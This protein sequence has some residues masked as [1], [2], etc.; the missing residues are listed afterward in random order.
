MIK[1]SKYVEKL[2]AYNITS[3][4][5]WADEA[6]K[7][8]LKLD[9]NE[10]P[11]DFPF[12]KDELQKISKERGILSWYPDYMT[13]KLSSKIS[14]YLSIPETNLSIFPGSD[15]ALETF[16]RAYLS[17]DDEV[18]VIA[19]TYENAFV[20]F[21]QT[22]AHIKFLDIPKPFQVDLSVISEEILLIKPK[23]VYLV[24][25]N[26]PCGY[27]V[28]TEEIEDLVK[29]HPHT[30]FIIDEAYI[31]FSD[32]SSSKDLVR[33]NENIA[34]FR[35][36]S[37]AFG[38]A[39]IRLGFMIAPLSIINVVE[40]IRNGKN[41]SM[42]SQRLGVCALDN[43]NKINIWIEDVKSSRDILSEWCKR[44]NIIFY[45]SHG[46]FLLFETKKPQELLLYLKSN[47]VYIRDRSKIIDSCVRITLGGKKET[48][49]L[50]SLLNN[51]MDLF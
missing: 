32:V 37:K 22:G 42:I 17:P 12:Y 23:M 31:E 19:P 39:G 46:N 38:L 34:I 4:D 24:N 15:V 51:V 20:F 7:D 8:I 28:K 35:T 26:N 9:W 5:V 41:I 49:K 21:L 1:P 6:P 18:L 44:N 30:I 45:P 10:A 29:Q 50:L 27:S 16:S 48:D 43:I 40:K 13:S 36:F 14:D 33:E 2:N 25:P 47:G 3:Q 11:Y